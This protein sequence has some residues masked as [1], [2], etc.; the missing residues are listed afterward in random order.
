MQ[1]RYRPTQPT[2]QSA[3]PSAT[4][5]V[6]IEP[7]GRYGRSGQRYRVIHDDTILIGSSG[8]PEFDTCRL[9]LDNGI[10]GKV[11]VW[12]RGADFPS[13]RINIAKGARLITEDGDRIGPIF[14]RWQPRSD[15]AQTAIL[16]PEGSC[17][18]AVTGSQVDRSPSK[19]EP[20]ARS[21][22]GKRA[23]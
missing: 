3:Q 13:M 10:T 2:T 18:T 21:P 9:L 14:A 8:D 5:V 17:R 19:K 16:G 7:T 12:R 1:Q 4:I 15:D 20:L 6:I 11:E 23:A 22:Q